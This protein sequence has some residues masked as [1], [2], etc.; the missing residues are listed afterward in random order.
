VRDGRTVRA[1]VARKPLALEAFLARF[2]A[3]LVVESGASAG[4]EHALD[5]SKL[6]LGRSGE[7]DVRLD[8]SEVSAEHAVIEFTGEGFRI[9]DLGSTNGTLVNGT[10]IDAHDLEAGDRLQVGRVALR[11]RLEARPRAPRVYCLPED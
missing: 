5:R 4:V 6:V 10:R 8:D 2:E 11:V 1:P 9:V 3:A 7:A